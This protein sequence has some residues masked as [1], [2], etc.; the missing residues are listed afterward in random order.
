MTATIDSPSKGGQFIDR[1]LAFFAGAAIAV[2]FL[3]GLGG[4]SDPNFSLAGP[5]TKLA[6]NWTSESTTVLTRMSEELI[7]QVADAF[8]PSGDS[9]PFATIGADGQVR[10][11]SIESLAP[12]DEVLSDDQDQSSQNSRAAIIVAVGRGSKQTSLNLSQSDSGRASGS[13][14][15]SAPF[16]LSTNGKKQSAEIHVELNQAKRSPGQRA[17][18][19][20]GHPLLC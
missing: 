8:V 6:G 11:L 19:I 15:F 1:F 10:V 18:P 5:E 17:G 4:G 2:W 13:K 9:A 20:R 7:I 12:E 3:G 16:Q 14:A